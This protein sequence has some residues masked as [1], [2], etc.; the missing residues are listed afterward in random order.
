MSQE[1]QDHPARALLAKDL[2]EGDIP[3]DGKEL[4]PKK[5]YQKYKDTDAFN[6]MEYNSTFTRRLHDLRKAVETSSE[7]KKVDWKKHPAKAFLYNSFNDKVIPVGYL[8]TIGPKGVWHNHCANHAAFSYLN[9]DSNFVRRLKF[10]E[11]QCVKK[12][13]RQL[14]DQIAFDLFHKNNPIK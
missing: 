13:K 1:W 12:H 3:I 14:D 4:G 6:G 7:A 8:D 9:C 5:V 10:V 2:K 11:T